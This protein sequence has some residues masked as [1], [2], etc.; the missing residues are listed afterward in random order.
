MAVLRFKN[1]LKFRTLRYFNTMSSHEVRQ[2]FF[3]YFKQLDHVYVPSTSVVPLDDPSLLF[4]NA[5]MNQ[6]LLM[7]DI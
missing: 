3:D 4:V 6:V 7:V 5:G 2:L 1:W